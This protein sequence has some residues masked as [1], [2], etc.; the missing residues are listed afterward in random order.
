MSLDSL[1]IHNFALCFIFNLYFR[2]RSNSLG[3]FI[4]RI[5]KIQ[6]RSAQLAA[7]RAVTKK[8]YN[9]LS[10]QKVQELKREQLKKK[11]FLKSIGKF[12]H[13]WIGMRQG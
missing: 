4:F 8:S 1:V 11:L 3:Y 7:V 6:A 12:L 5:N 2:V 9:F 10:S 13:S